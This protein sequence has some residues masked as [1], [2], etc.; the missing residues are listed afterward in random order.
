MHRS[1]QTE[2][3]SRFEWLLL[4][5]VIIYSFFVGAAIV[6]RIFDEDGSQRGAHLLYVLI[7]SYVLTVCYALIL[8]R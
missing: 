6:F 8:R 4:I 1:E 7:A 3:L 5:R 2:L